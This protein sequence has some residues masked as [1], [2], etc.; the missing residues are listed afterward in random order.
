M[1]ILGRSKEPQS[2][3]THADA[4][5]S[6]SRWFLRKRLTQFLGASSLTCYTNLF[7]KEMDQLDIYA[8]CFG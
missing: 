6:C 1:T 3:S 7:F 2:C 5:P 8:P 4:Q